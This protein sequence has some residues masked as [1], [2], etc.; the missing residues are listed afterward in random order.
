MFASR[1][2]VIRV[3]SSVGCNGVHHI[4][5]SHRCTLYFTN[6][7]LLQEL[8]E[9]IVAKIMKYKCVWYNIRHDTISVIKL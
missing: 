7:V 9:T 8:I 6:N 1:R 3:S 5:E 4:F 2:R